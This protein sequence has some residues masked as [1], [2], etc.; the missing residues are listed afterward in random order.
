V[1]IHNAQGKAQIVFPLDY[2][3]HFQVEAVMPEPE[4]TE[5]VQGHMV[6]HFPAKQEAAIRF[7]ISPELTGS[8]KGTMMVNNEPIRLSHFIYR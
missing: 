2:L 4:A 7:F 1:R 3:E 5:M 6:Y 8:V